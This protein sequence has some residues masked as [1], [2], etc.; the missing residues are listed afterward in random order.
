MFPPQKKKTPISFNNLTF[1]FFPF[2]YRMKKR[3]SGV[4]REIIFELIASKSSLLFLPIQQTVLRES[5]SSLASSRAHAH[6]HAQL[7]RCSL[8]FFFWRLLLKHILMLEAEIVAPLRNKLPVLSLVTP[9]HILGKDT[10]VTR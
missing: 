10:T 5:A 6:A 4:E 2:F 7:Q 3:G 8:F 9:R 1:L